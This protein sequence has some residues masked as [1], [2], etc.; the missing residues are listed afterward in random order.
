MIR[1]NK[2][3]TKNRTNNKRNY[4]IIKEITNENENEK[5]GYIFD[6][7][8]AR[9]LVNQPLYFPRAITFKISLSIE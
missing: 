1:R 4:I 6:A 5:N 8:N 2:I 3:V 7:L 9:M